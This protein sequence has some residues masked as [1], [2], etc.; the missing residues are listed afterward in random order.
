M[1]DTLSTELLHAAFMADF[2]RIFEQ[3]DP[4]KNDE[5]ELEDD[6]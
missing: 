5:K 4:N 1:T 3:P 6:N 2:C